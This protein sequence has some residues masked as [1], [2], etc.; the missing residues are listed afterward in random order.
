MRNQHLWSSTNTL[1]LQS[2]LCLFWNPKTKRPKKSK[3][4]NTLMNPCWRRIQGDLCYSQSSTA[5][6]GRCTRKNSLRFGLLMRS[7]CIKISKTGRDSLIMRNISLSMFSLFL[8][9]QMVSSW[10]TSQS[11]L[12]VKFKLLKLEL[13]M[14]SKSPW[15]TSMRRRIRCS[16]TLTLKMKLKKIIFSRQH[17]MCQWLTRKRNGL[18]NGS[19]TTIILYLDSLHLQLSKVFSSP[20]RSVRSFGWR[21][22]LSCLVW[23]SLM[24]LSPETKVFTLISLVSFILWWITNSRKKP[25]T[26]SSQ[27]QLKSRRN[28]FRKP[29]Q[30]SSLAWTAQ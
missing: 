7:I 27:K 30:L 22:A 18:W 13:S 21:S 6:S 5:K 11:S 20:D 28:S 16:S 10:R 23:P 25:S 1:Q 2:T 29:F 24:S 14:G 4:L 3:D 19:T 9:H 17:K 8:Q 26:R 12:C 15:R